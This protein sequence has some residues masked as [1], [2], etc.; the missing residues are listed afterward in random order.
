MWMR[1]V[2]LSLLLGCLLV[3]SDQLLQP[4]DA[5]AKSEPRTV[6][7]FR[8]K[9]PRDQTEVRFAQFKDQKAI[10]VVFLGTECPINNLFLPVLAQLH[11]AYGNKG[12]AFVGIYSN[13]QDT[14]DR[15]AAHA[16]R[17]KITFAMVKDPNNE[18]ADLFGAKRTPEAFVL[19]PSGKILY[20]GRIDDQFGIDFQRPGQ[21]RQR[22]LAQALDEVLAGKAVTTANTPVAGCLISRVKVEKREGSVTYARDISRIIQKNCQECH[23]P[24]QIGPF[25]LQTFEDAAAWADTIREVVADRRMPPW[26]ADPRFGTFLNDRSLKPEDQKALLTW[27]DNG[28]PRGDDKDLPKPRDFKEGWSIGTPDLVIK[29]PKPYDVPAEAPRGGIPY[30]FFSVP[31]NFTEDRWV[32]RA[33]CQVGAPEVVHHIVVYIFGPGEIFRPDGPVLTGTAPGDMP[34]I[35]EPGYAK[36]IPAGSRL[37]F[38]MHY[39]PNGKA[40]TDQSSV[41]IV[42]AKEKP[43]HRVRTRPIYPQSFYS[44]LDRIPAGADNYPIETTFTFR[45]DTHILAFMPHMHLRGKD[46]LYEHIDAA[47]KKETLLSVPRYLFG[48]QTIYRPT[49]PIAMPKGTKMH[50]LAHYDNSEKNLSNP[51]P[52]KNVYWGDQTWEEMMIGWIDYYIDAETP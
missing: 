45:E 11:K 50:C 34:L 30:Q 8:L 5:R 16:R 43:K 36:K 1:L 35:L 52:K 42:F 32:E 20:Q 48:W 39:T 9:D 33:E 26:H 3:T 31:T 37:V 49:K 2:A 27:I 13:R 25:A 10:V 4:V 21:P 18:V 17:N 19:N 12:V 22:D 6:P 24:A 14:P 23:R 41:G 29:M 46:F 15:V 38:Q 47:G 51:N 44:H 7:D 28:C 40:Q